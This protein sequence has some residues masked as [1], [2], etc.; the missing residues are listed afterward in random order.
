MSQISEA[1][2]LEIHQKFNCIKKLFG[3]V[4]P[5]S[6]ISSNVNGIFFASLKMKLL[7]FY[8]IFFMQLSHNENVIYWNTKS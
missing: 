1:S 7:L 3:S 8:Q 2:F 4:S 6:L 5:P